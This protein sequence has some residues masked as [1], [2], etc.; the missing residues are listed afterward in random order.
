MHSVYTPDCGCI[1]VSIL[2]CDLAGYHTEAISPV[3]ISS[4]NKAISKQIHLYRISHTGAIRYR[5]LLYH[6]NISRSNTTCGFLG[7][8]LPLINVIFAQDFENSTIGSL[9]QSMELPNLLRVAPYSLH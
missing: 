8:I 1:A 9:P 7:D 6:G 4:S 5:M 3:A 2:L